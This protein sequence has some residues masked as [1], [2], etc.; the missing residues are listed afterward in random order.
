MKSNR[1]FLIFAAIAVAV[2]LSLFFFTTT[3]S[4]NGKYEEDSMRY[5]MPALFMA[6]EGVFAQEKTGPKQYVYETF[7]TPGYPLFLAIFH[8]KLRIPLNG[9]IFLQVLL[10]ILTAVLVY[11]LTPFT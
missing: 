3:Y 5:M 9:I 1:L 11:R 8:H 4:P 2:K 10:S 7:R 6:R